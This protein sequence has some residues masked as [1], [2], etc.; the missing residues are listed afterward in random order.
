MTAKIG[1]T[2]YKRHYLLDMPPRMSIEVADYFKPSFM[3]TIRMKAMCAQV[4]RRACSD[5][6]VCE[7]ALIRGFAHAEWQTVYPS[8]ASSYTS[9]G[10]QGQ[11]HFSRSMEATCHAEI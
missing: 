6:C 8:P 10:P 9:Y 5:C 2:K 7:A 4:G 3:H 1:I 11:A